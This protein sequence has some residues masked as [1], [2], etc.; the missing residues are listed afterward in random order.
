MGDRNARVL[1]SSFVGNPDRSAG[2]EPRTFRFG[3]FELDLHAGELRRNGVRVKL[4]DQPF[5]ILVQLLERRGEVVTRE[6]LRGRLWG[7]DTFVDFDHSLNAAIRRLRDALGDS[8]ENPRFVE[9]VARRGYRFLAPVGAAAQPSNG[10][11]PDLTPSADSTS[12]HD[13]SRRIWWIVAGAGAIVLILIG[14]RLGV[15]LGRQ[16]AS[17]APMRI[18]Q[19]TANPLDDRVRAA[20]ISPDG[21]YLAF[22]DETGFYLRQIDTGETHTITLPEGMKVQSIG[23]FPDNNH[24]IIALADVGKHASLWEI[25]A[26]GGSPRKLNDDGRSPAV[27]PDGKEVAFIA[28]P[29]IHQQIWLMD[30]DGS[31]PHQLAG[32]EGDYFGALAW[33]P[34]G[35]RL[36]C[37]RGRDA[38]GYGV[39]GEIDIVNF[40]STVTLTSLTSDRGALTLGLNGPLA[41]TSDGHLVY[42]LDEG[43]PHSSDSNLWSVAVDA[44]G[45]PTSAKT[46]LTNDSGQVFSLSASANGKHIAFLKGVPEPDVY[47]ARLERT[48]IVGEPQRLTLD[49]RADIPYDW[50]LD[51]KEVIFTS[52][53]TGV[54]SIYRQA[55]DQ[56]VPEMLVR[57][58][59]PLIESRL[60]PDGTQL[61]YVESPKW[62]DINSSSPL[63]RVPLAGGAPQ[64][65]AEA[66]WISNHQCARS[67]A[68]ICLFS[69]VADRTLTFFTFDPFKGKGKQIFKIQGELSQFYN[70]S[71][72]PD[73]T[74][75][76]IAKAK[77]EEQPRVGLVSLR[78]GGERW[79]DIQART[80]ISSLDWAADSRSLWAAS[81]GDEENALLNIDLQGHTRVVWRPGKKS[82]GWAIPSRDGRFLAIYV[83]STSANV[84]MLERP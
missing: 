30:A 31:Q 67:P 73:G 66:N 45:K 52:D 78:G 27:S 22:S 82:I 17:P 81:A 77:S 62:G 18:T 26:W 70:W 9:T 79:L 20:S 10:T 64:K 7:S 41:W 63:M 59:R 16:Y 11:G 69:I 29:H 49:D 32:K 48:E 56:T 21:R 40:D 43:P 71:L 54:L 5:Q 13:T 53:R 36:A 3:L 51:S 1:H 84:W 23:W 12:A 57:G 6:E 2:E 47:V 65:I 42:S 55:I 33:S 14:V 83:G 35:A 4:Q 15:L 34:D 58:V 46:R 44:Q 61:L 28:G 72:S 24:M 8:A 19:L 76:A 38:Y 37:T 25:S 50:T 68:T 60:S 39:D 74:T 75:L 80:G